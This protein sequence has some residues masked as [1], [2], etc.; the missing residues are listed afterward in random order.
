M[1]I[2]SLENF[3]DRLRAKYGDLVVIDDST[4]KNLKTNVKLEFLHLD[5]TSINPYK[6]FLLYLY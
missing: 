6:K 3:K 5:Y 4:Y 2:I 1:N